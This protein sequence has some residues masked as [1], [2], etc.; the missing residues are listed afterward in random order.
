M[1]HPR[2]RGWT[3]G[4]GHPKLVVWKVQRGQQGLAEVI[5]LEYQTRQVVLGQVLVLYL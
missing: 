3:V 1:P 5:I 4:I 2:Q